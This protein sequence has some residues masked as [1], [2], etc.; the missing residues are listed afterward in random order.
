MARV[1]T[2]EK[3]LMIISI[4]VSFVLVAGFSALCYMKQKAI[5]EVRKESDKLAK[6]ANE[7]Q[8]K[9]DMLGTKEEERDRLAKEIHEYEKILPDAKEVENLMTMLSEQ[10]RRSG[11]TVRDFSLIESRGARG[12][13]GVAGGA[14]EKVR[15]ECSVSSSKEGKGYFCACKFLNL[16]E[17]Y[18]RFIAV[19]TLSIAGGRKGDAAMV[20]DVSAHTYMFTGK[21]ASAVKK[22]G[23]VRR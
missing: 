10:G 16:L 19:D 17:R 3:T 20:M 1:R 13:G 5:E 6:Q 4:I 18:E 23:A 8:K 2:P 9:I 21:K 12:R 14:Y 11:C 15:F 7:L 22:P